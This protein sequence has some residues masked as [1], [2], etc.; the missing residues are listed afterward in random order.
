MFGYVY[1]CKQELKVKDY[2]KF[3]A[4]YCGLCKKIKSDFG[5]L[6]R[7]TLNYDMTFVAILMDALIDSRILLK[8]DRCI[9][10]PIQTKAIVVNTPALEAA[11]FCNISL[12]Y[13]KLLDDAKD[14]KSKVSSVLSRLLKLY[15][16]KSE[17]KYDE[18]KKIIDEKLTDL[19]NAEENPAGKSLDEITHPFA[20]LLG[21]VF[22]VLAKLIEEVSIDKNE[23]DNI[24]W[25]GYYLGRW[26]YIIDAYDDLEKDMKKNEFNPI[27]NVLNIENLEYNDFKAKI[28]ERIKFSLVSAATNCSDKLR[29]ITL[30]K[31]ED[32]LANILD[33]GLM[34][35][36]DKIFNRSVCTNEKSV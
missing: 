34:E 33:L 3:R 10:H 12:Y 20:V 24:Y 30:H 4:Y 35:K 16:H 31:N 25:L 11:A 7:L 14:E 5:N 15:M 6:P 9:I 36:M 19:S 32:L 18:L 1:P 13:Y 2:D 8:K 17:Y 27:S 21:T 22:A 29:N 28:E 26:I 23:S